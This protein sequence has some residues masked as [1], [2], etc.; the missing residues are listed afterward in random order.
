[1]KAIS[2]C[3]ITGQHISG[4]SLRHFLRLADLKFRMNDSRF[5]SMEDK[6]EST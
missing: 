6:D 3:E 1:M 2:Y 4:I 5:V